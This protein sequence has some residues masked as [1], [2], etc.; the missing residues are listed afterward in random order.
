MLK[1]ASENPHAIISLLIP[2]E[3]DDN[4]GS[5][6]RRRAENMLPWRKINF[7]EGMTEEQLM[8]ERFRTVQMMMDDADLNWDDIMRLNNWT[9]G[10][11]GEG[12]TGDLDSMAMKWGEE[13]DVWPYQLRQN[14]F[15]LEEFVLRLSGRVKGT[16]RLIEWKRV[17]G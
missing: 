13:S 15:T 6:D 9:D 3:T 1:L 4:F 7:K 12:G 10:G 8:Y 11:D 17:L 2:T 16:E 14:D 5:E